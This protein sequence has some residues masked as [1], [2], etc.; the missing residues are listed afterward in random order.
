MGIQIFLSGRCGQSNLLRDPAGPL[1]QPV[2]ASRAHDQILASASFSADTGVE[3]PLLITAIMA[4]LRRVSGTEP[5]MKGG[6][7]PFGRVK[8]QLLVTMFT[9]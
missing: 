3:V 6:M 1:T 2:S 9:A 7:I 8:D 4:R 5:L